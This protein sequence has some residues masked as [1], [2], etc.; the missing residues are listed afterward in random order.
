MEIYKIQ[1]VEGMMGNKHFEKGG[2][3]LT[4]KQEDLILAREDEFADDILI[5]SKGGEKHGRN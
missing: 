1:E 4:T 3:P 2:E 5:E